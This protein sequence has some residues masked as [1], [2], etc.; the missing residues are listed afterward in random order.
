M[1]NN[2]HLERSKLNDIDGDIQRVERQIG[3]QHRLA[4]LGSKVSISNPPEVIS[5]KSE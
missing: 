2:I 4:T 3:Y 1:L 5:T